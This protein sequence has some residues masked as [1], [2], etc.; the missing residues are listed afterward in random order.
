MRRVC[1]LGGRGFVEDNVLLGWWLFWVVPGAF[2]LVIGNV[3]CDGSD[4]W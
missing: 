4:F 3:R 2:V 1:E